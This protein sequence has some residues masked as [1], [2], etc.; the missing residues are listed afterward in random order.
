MEVLKKKSPF[1]IT[2]IK[3]Q[4]IHGNHRRG[5]IT[6]ICAFATP[7]KPTIGG[8]ESEKYN[9]MQHVKK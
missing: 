7:S 9:S 4:M 5:R 2:T 6:I 1:P 8:N 3:T